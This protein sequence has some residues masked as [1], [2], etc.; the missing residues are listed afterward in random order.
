MVPGLGDPRGIPH[1]HPRQDVA[2]SVGIA[3]THGSAWLSFPGLTSLLLLIFHPHSITLI[4]LSSE[5]G[6]SELKLERMLHM[7]FGAMVRLGPLFSKTQESC[8][9]SPFPQSKSLHFFL[10][11]RHP[12]S[13]PPSYLAIQEPDLLLHMQGSRPNLPLNIHPSTVLSD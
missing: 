1:P 4:A 11:P 3:G 13:P 5:E 10:T 8:T 9:P 7:V 2:N 6:T 12:N